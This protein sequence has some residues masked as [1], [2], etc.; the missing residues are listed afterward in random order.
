MRRMVVSRVT[1]YSIAFK[2]IKGHQL[3]SFIRPFASALLHDDKDP[4][5]A[6]FSKIKEFCRKLDEASTHTTR[7]L[8]N[9]SRSDGHVVITVKPSRRDGSFSDSYWLFIEL[10]EVISDVYLNQE[11]GLS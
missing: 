8:V 7:L 1:E 11:G 4:S 10:V 2:S 3:I 9:R 6:F 5:V